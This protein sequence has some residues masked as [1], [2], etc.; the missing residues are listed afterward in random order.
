MGVVRKQ[1]F[2]LLKSFWQELFQIHRV[3]FLVWSRRGAC[4]VGV[5]TN[6]LSVEIG[7]SKERMNV[8]HLGQGGPISDSTEFSRIHLDVF[9][10]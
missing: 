9:R 2:S 8:L 3:S 6:K 1:F 10:E 5:V 7:E 4:D